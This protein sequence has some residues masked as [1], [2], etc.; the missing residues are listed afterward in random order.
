[1]C[2][3]YICMLTDI[4]VCVYM[5]MLT[6]IYVH[7]SLCILCRRKR[8]QV[9][10]AWTRGSHQ[11]SSWNW[12]VCLQHPAVWI[13]TEVQRTITQMHIFD[14]T[15]LGWGRF[16]FSRCQ[17]KTKMRTENSQWNGFSS[18]QIHSSHFTSHQICY[19]NK[20]IVRKNVAMTKLKK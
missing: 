2:S 4:N 7:T 18:A 12:K 1:M 6:E 5:H 8:D 17:E 13:W 11:V 16:F 14:K 10:N 15:L 20:A 9:S 3:L 19:K